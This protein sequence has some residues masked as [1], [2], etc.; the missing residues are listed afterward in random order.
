MS[1]SLTRWFRLKKYQYE[2]TFALTM[3]NPTER[4]VCSRSRFIQRANALAHVPRLHRLPHLQHA[5]HCSLPLPPG[6]HCDHGRSGLLLLVRED[7][8]LGCSVYGS[9]TR[10]ASKS[11]GVSRCPACCEKSTGKHCQYTSRWTDTRESLACARDGT[12]EDDVNRSNQIF[13]KAIYGSST[14]P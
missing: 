7:E 3:L 14:S 4:F 5:G 10:F 9:S 12:V 8:E 6:T 11:V 13:T 1:P 2:A